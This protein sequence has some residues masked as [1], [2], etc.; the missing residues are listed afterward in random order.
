MSRIPC[1]G[2]SALGRVPRLYAHFFRP[3]GACMSSGAFGE[4]VRSML[5]RDP[6]LTHL[7]LRY[8]RFGEAAA[9]SALGAA[10]SSPLSAVISIDLRHNELGEAGGRTLARVLQQSRVCAL[11]LRT[12]GLRD[13]GAAAV[14]SLLYGTISPPLTDLNIWNNQISSDGARK[15]A[16]CLKKNR[17]LEVLN[18][19]SNCLEDEGALAVF[20]ALVGHPSLAV[21]RV[22]QAYI[23]DGAAAV[24]AQLLGQ[25]PSLRTIDLRNNH[26]T[27]R[28]VAAIV[29]ALY[30][31]LDIART[32]PRES[33]GAPGLDVLDLQG[34][35]VSPRG[36]RM[37]RDYVA[38]CEVMCGTTHAPPQL[39][40]LGGQQGS[41]SRGLNAKYEIT[42]GWS[43][44]VGP[45]GLNLA[46]ETPYGW[47]AR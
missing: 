10:L 5:S 3:R 17:R 8:Q 16:S 46:A 39:I 38:S 14:G 21:L 12:N 25:T 40:N 27:D 13:I 1:L 34:N 23:G 43:Q 36:Y 32:S 6:A 22:R 11:D 33:A 15:L 30:V 19:G 42:T 18:L 28:T 24:L 45:R 35:E 29:E 47:D 7:E 31:T 37:L 20:D 9:A 4:D 44:A 26:I 41:E 2:R